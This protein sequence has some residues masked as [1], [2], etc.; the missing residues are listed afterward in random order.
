MS[1]SKEKIDGMERCPGVKKWLKLWRVRRERRRAK[2]A[3]EA[4]AE[5]K[6]YRGWSI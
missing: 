4:P 3:P 5:Y 1:T 2:V 6:R